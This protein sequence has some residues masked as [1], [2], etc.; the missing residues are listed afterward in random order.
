MEAKNRLLDA[1]NV[2]FVQLSLRRIL[3]RR[4]DLLKNK[5]GNIELTLTPE[6][7]LRFTRNFHL[8]V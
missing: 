5:N 1:R 2:D 7:T 6:L 3:L 8:Y 4:K